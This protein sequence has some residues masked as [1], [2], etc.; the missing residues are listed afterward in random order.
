VGFCFIRSIDRAGEW[1][2]G[3]GNVCL[4]STTAAAK[5]LFGIDRTTPEPEF[6]S[7]QI[8]I[9]LKQESIFQSLFFEDRI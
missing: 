9:V 4:P 2:D 5:M 7:T 6:F 3:G 1:Q 8:F